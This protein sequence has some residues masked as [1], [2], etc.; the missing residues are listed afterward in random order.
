M[1]THSPIFFDANNTTTFVKLT[2]SE[3]PDAKAPF[4]VSKFVDLSQLEQRLRVQAICFE[5]N[6]IAFFSKS[7]VLVEGTSDALLL[8]HL[9]RLVHDGKGFERGNVALCRIDGK[10]SIA[11]YRAFFSSFDVQVLVI[12]DLD[13]I[14]DGFD[15]LGPSQKTNALRRELLT[16]IDDELA[17]HTASPP[18]GSQLR[19]HAKKT[20]T[21]ERWEEL[22]RLFTAA[23]VLM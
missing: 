17:Q 22:Q 19:E 8:P 14:L 23:V 6:S 5:N 13:C 10:G 7:V 15:K 11:R 9:A 4:S 20:T 16:I 2:K 3:S 12:A 21:R 18:S 1:T